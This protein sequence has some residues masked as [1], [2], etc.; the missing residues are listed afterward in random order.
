MFNILHQNGFRIIN[1]TDGDLLKEAVRLIDK[2]KA[3]GINLNYIRNRRTDLEP[4]RNAQNIK[5]LTVNDYPS[6]YQYDYSVIHSLKNLEQ[7]SVY[8]TDKKEIDFS[9]FPFLKSV[10]LTWRPKAKSLFDCSQLQRLF[11]NRYKGDDLHE[12]SRLKNLKYLRVNLG[13]I[14]SLSGLKEITE[15][16]ELLLMQTTKLEDIED[17]FKLRHLKY[18]RIDNCRKVKNI[19]AVKKI[20]IPLLEIVGTTPKE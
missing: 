20:G 6:T 9:V 11:I 13:S 3:D 16:E 8:T 12:V 15:L 18:L 4:L 2:G 7:L 19:S 1:L 14:T 17:L 5:C 10:A